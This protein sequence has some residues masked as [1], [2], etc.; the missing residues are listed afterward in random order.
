MKIDPGSESL[1]QPMMSCK[2]SQLDSIRCADLV[3]DVREMAFD[4]VFADGK[5]VSDLA[6]RLATEH[7]PE[8]FELPARQAECLTAPA[9]NLELAE[10]C[11]HLGR[12][13]AS[14]CN[15]LDLDLAVIGGS[16]ALGFGATFFNAA[17]ESLDIAADMEDIPVTTP[18]G[19]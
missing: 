12:A 14:V 5:P 4:G 10:T 2:A 11:G 9:R 6:I 7:R 17:Q 13:V 18:P 1:Q 16:V 8:D 19:W 3:E 15:V